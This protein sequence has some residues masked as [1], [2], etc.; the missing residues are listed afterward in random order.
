MFFTVCLW[1]VCIPLLCC[2]GGEG[3]ETLHVREFISITGWNLSVIV[4]KGQVWSC[5]WEGH[6][7]VSIEFV[8]HRVYQWAWSVCGKQCTGSGIWTG[9][10]LM[11]MPQLDEITTFVGHCTVWTE[12]GQFAARPEI[13]LY[14]SPLC[15]HSG[16]E[17]LT[18]CEWQFHRYVLCM[19]KEHIYFTYRLYTYST[20]VYVCV[21][22]AA[23]PWGLRRL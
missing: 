19:Y 23:E 2:H 15:K 8:W 22:R 7:S 14:N 16:K 3:G 12:M 5:A 10:G 20:F 9:H 6:A 4:W 21:S 13:C 18:I 1:C 17:L 11:H